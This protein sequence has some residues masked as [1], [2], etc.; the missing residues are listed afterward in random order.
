[1]VKPETLRK[2][3]RVEFVPIGSKMPLG[4]EGR[5]VTVTVGSQAC[6]GVIWDESPDFVITAAKDDPW[7]KE[8][9]RVKK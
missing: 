9:R 5:I 8:I 1:M 7:W 2:G 6:L 3:E 4:C